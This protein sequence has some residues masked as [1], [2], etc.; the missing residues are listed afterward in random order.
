[1]AVAPLSVTLFA[2]VFF[3]A[4]A[5]KVDRNQAMVTGAV[6]MLLLGWTFD[7]YTVHEAL[8]AIYFDTLALIFGMSLIGNILIRSGLFKVLATRV[9]GY[10]HGNAQLVLVLLVLITY[11]FSLV[12]NNLATMLIMLP[13][14]LSLCNTVKLEPVPIVIAEL[15]A[16]NLGGAST[17]IGDFPNMIIGAAG[18]LHFDDFIGGMMA[19]CLVML[20]ILLGYFGKRMV[21]VGNGGVM[22][23]E[24]VAETMDIDHYLLRV[25]FSI[26]GVMLLALVFSYPIGLQP[27]VIALM[28]GATILVFGRVPREALF[29]AMS[30]GDILFF[31]ALFIMIGG[32]QSAG[33]LVTLH[34][35]IITW[36]GKNPTQ[37]LLLLMVMS[38]F[39]TPFLN[40][41]PTTALLV[42]V[43]EIMNRDFPGSPVWWALSLGVLAG[44]SATLSGA[45][46]GP[47]V[48]S[49][50]LHQLEERRHMFRSGWILD[51]GK[52]RQ[53]GIPIAGVFLIFSMIYIAMGIR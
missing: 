3:L 9:A 38:A 20:A 41:G 43:A 30:G 51:S 40:A 19:P 1:M 2:L 28:A 14:T 48:A 31:A 45:T 26:L 36:G 47:V 17:L 18:K 33:V 21:R 4:E 44:S 53:W 52:Y 22:S 32:L 11:G 13:L 29:K 7:F 27:G 42:P 25:G 49:Q 8:R 39:L 37:S 10:S 50:M 34:D 12:V 23:G 6:L 16:S 5:E 15:I 24:L 46:A 35:L